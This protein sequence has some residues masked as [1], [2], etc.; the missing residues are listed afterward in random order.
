MK[1]LD[2]VNQV[3][4]VGLETTGQ[5]ANGRIW[6][7]LIPYYGLLAMCL[8]SLANVTE[9]ALYGAVTGWVGFVAMFLGLFGRV[10][11][12]D[13]FQH[14]PAHF[15]LIPELFGWSKL[16]IGLLIESL[17]L[18]GAALLFARAFLSNELAGNRS[19]VTRW[20]QLTVLWLMTNLLY[21]LAGLFLP[22][23]FAPLLTGFTRRQLLFD[24]VGLPI[25]YV[26]ILAPFYFA[27]PSAAIFGY[28]PAK[29]IGRSV[30]MFLRR[31]LTSLFF[32]GLILAGPAVI[33]AIVNRAPA[34]IEQYRPE[35]IVTLLLGGI[36]VE[37]L[38]SFFWM[39][40]AVRF[41]ADETDR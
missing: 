10:V 23:L 21:I 33:A 14:Y 35:L 19:L 13:Q 9:S 3:I 7:I 16:L 34:I 32:A 40:S 27:L 28:S 11:P 12:V 15:L 5:L 20:P 38:S 6:L 1:L 37:L 29:A 4:R 22:E 41:L 25:V 2:K 30:G 31:P 17:V 24:F 18:S 39:G 8:W 26:L 36:A